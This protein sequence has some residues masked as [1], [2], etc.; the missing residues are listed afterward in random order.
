MTSADSLKPALFVSQNPTGRHGLVPI[1]HFN[2]KAMFGFFKK[3][4]PS[5]TIRMSQRTKPGYSDGRMVGQL[6]KE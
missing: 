6:T 3:L 1:P 5:A 2:P 4:N